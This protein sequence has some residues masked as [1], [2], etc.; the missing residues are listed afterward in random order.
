[1]IRSLTYIII[2]CFLSACGSQEPKEAIA[3]DT[4]FQLP[5]GA[6]PIKYIKNH[7]YIEGNVDGARGSFLFDTGADNF[8]FDSVFFNQHI[9]DYKKVAVAMLPGVGSTPQ[10]T[11]VILDT[12][13]FQFG[14]NI[15][16]TKTVPV[17]GLKE[18][19][20]DFADGIIGKSY[21]S[22]KIMQIDYKHEY[23]K[24]YDSIEM[25]S[26]VGF[27]KIPFIQDHR[28]LLLPLKIELNNSINIEGNFVFDLGS[29]HAVTFNSPIAKQFDLAKNIDYKV[30]YETKYGGVGGQSARY[31]FWVGSIKI[32]DYELNNFVGEY[33][34]D[35]QGA[36][37]S[38][39]HSGLLGHEILERFDIIIDL[40][41]IICFFFL[42]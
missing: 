4:E 30:K 6:I 36:L 22:N 32:G 11:K 2:F 40:P 5:A 35:T 25:I 14:N 33:S 24:L 19:V 39:K 42:A 13:S 15:Y 8:Y 31:D 1:M 18:I 21:F 16:Q 41:I 28:R 38:D 26:T 7:L 12:V 17:F 23:I 29:G 9:F 37:S 27:S 10:K 34:T 3:V 20:G